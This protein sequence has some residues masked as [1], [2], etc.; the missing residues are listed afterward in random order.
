MPSLDAS[1][2]LPFLR[3]NK[4]YLDSPFVLAPLAGYTDLAFRLLCRE[5]G[6]GLVFSEMISSH[7]LLYNQK[8]TWEMLQSIPEER[9]LVVQLFGSDPAIMAAAVAAGR[10]PARRRR[11]PAP[12]RRRAPAPRRRAPRA[13][14]AAA[15]KHRHA[16]SGLSGLIGAFLH[17]ER[18]DSI[19]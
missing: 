14:R 2:A 18:H 4:L 11:A 12:R 8:K 17:R 1:G 5:L 19:C 13:R 16:A 6:A 7:G 9:P 10:A 15:G 3:H